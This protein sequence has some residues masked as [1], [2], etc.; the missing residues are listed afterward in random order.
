VGVVVLPLQAYSPA[1]PSL[2]LAEGRVFL[3]LGGPLPAHSLVAS[4]CLTRN[5]LAKSAPC[6][7]RY[8]KCWCQQPFVISLFVSFGPFV[9]I[10]TAV[11][12][13]FSSTWKQAFLRGRL[14]TGYSPDALVCSASAAI[15]KTYDQFILEDC[16]WAWT[17]FLSAANTIGY[18]FLFTVDFYSSR[19]QLHDW[20]PW[21]VYFE[22]VGLALCGLFLIFGAVGHFTVYLFLRHL[23]PSQASLSL[24]YSSLFCTV[25]RGLE[26][27]PR[28]VS[29]DSVQD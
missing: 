17:S 4:T 12:T 18:L 2:S 16:R 10:L 3:F 19:S 23:Q 9:I 29:H 5:I 20:L 22:Y 28:P 11:Y 1:L 7:I 21:S 25:K 13:L 15:I 26:L 6:P 14:R 8:Q 27:P 24:G